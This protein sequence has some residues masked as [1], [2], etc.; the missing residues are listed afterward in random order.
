MQRFNL[1]KISELDVRK[2]Y[3]IKISN[4]FAALENLNV[5]ED[6]NRS[7]ENIKVSIKISATESLG[8]Y[9]RKQHKPWFDEEFSTFLDQR[10]QAKMQW[11]QNPKQSNV[12]N[13]NNVKREASRHFRDKKK[14]YLNELETNSKN[15]NIR[16]LYTGISDFKKGYQP[17]TTIVKNEEGD[18]VADCHSILARWRIYFSQL[19]SVH[20][21]SDVGQTKIHTYCTG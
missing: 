9:E 3:Q 2:Q 19:C 10:K 12:D 8:L 4:R 1:K 16:D 13:L 6:I 21:V 17:R 7:W 20:G 15:K 5:S 14:E 11:L 18:L